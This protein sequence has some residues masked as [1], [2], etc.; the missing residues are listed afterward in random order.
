ME[1]ENEY[2][3]SFFARNTMGNCG[4]SIEGVFEN[5]GDLEALKEVI[6]EKV[7]LNPEE[8]IIINVQKFPI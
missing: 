5:M 8:I 1:L 2:F 7:R 3:V 6:A 4:V